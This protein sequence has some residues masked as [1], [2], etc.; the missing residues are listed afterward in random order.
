MYLCV[1]KY[2]SVMNI[3]GIITGDIVNSR[4]IQSNERGILLDVIHMVVEDLKSIS[5]LQL[6]IFRGDSF[7]MVVDNPAEALKVAILLRAGLMSKTPENY[8]KPWAARLS[9]G[10]GDISYQADK[11]VVSDGEAF[12]ISGH[13]FD[14]I[15]KRRL[16]VKTR[17]DTI[18]A[19]LK[20]ST[21]FADD[22]ISGWSYSQAQA[23]Y[24]TLLYKK[25][26]KEIAVQLNKTAQN[27]SKLLGV[28][29]EE[30][31]CNYL[32]RY[33]SLIIEQIHK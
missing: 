27:I 10:V 5:T 18:N 7:Q 11:V 24:L 21:A 31:I 12:Q 3:K 26:R 16:I 4:S 15:G 17:W 1:V 32:E 22:I 19:E 8:R 6:E 9:L 25:T 28:A 14:E 23:V 30:L 20:V 2:L 29:K 33:H 13:E